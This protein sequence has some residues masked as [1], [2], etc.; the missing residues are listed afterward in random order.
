M[1]SEKISRS[2]DCKITGKYDK[3]RKMNGGFL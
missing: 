2:K 3:I 1:E